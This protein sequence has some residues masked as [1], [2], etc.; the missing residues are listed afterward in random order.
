MIDPSKLCKK[1]MKK[2]IS[3]LVVVYFSAPGA[4]KWSLK[5]RAAV[6]REICRVL[7]HW[8]KINTLG[9]V[10]CCFCLLYLGVVVKAECNKIWTIFES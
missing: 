8:A 1:I 9:R 6:A 4:S 3:S 10:G 5:V 2:R 7:R